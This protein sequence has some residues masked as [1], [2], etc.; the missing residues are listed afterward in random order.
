MAPTTPFFAEHL[1]QA[2]QEGSDPE[3]VHLASWPE[4]GRID[5]QL[6]GEMADARRIV[7]LALKQREESGLKIRQPLSKLTVRNLPEPSRA[8]VEEEV[9]VEK[10]IIDETIAREVELDT[11]L[12]PE[13]REKGMV[14]N[15]MRRVQEWRKE[16]KLN[17]ADR[18]HYML[19]T[20]KDEAAVAQKYRDKIIVETGLSDLTIEVE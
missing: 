4:A 2:V 5:T 9:N 11:E 8:I 7:S 15:L 20:T 12:T 13:L 3:S 10:I 17:I 16:Q 1:F 6:L 14:R 19:K 18:P